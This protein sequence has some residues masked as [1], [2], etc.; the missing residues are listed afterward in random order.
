MVQLA[1]KKCTVDCVEWRVSQSVRR[2]LHQFDQEVQRPIPFN[3]CSIIYMA[4]LSFDYP[5]RGCLYSSII[6]L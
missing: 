2:I 6:Q 3:G 5:T 4:R 1:K